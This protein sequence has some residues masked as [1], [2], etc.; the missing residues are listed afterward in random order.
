MRRLIFVSHQIPW[1]YDEN[2]QSFSLRRGHEAQ[3]A[4]SQSLLSSY[5]LVHIGWAKEGKV[6]RHPSS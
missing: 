4:G 6:D 5:K 2:T 1:I 3:F